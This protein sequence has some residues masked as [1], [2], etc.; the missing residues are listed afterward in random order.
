MPAVAPAVVKERARALR[1]KGA[2]ALRRH[3]D[4][5]VGTRRRVLTESRDLGRTEPF[6]K[7]R[8][9]TPAEPGAILDVTIAGHDGQQL[10]A[11]P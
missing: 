8:L 4:G 5:E 7:V 1:Q 9:A 10:L 11:E 2:A 3:L 6:T